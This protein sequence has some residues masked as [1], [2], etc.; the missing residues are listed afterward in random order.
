M[1][2][3]L[4]MEHQTAKIHNLQNDNYSVIAKFQRP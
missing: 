4:K 1:S 2:V 3:V